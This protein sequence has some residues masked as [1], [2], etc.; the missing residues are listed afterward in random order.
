MLSHFKY[1][2]YK[3][4][5]EFSKE[6]NC[7]YGKVINIRDLVSYEANSVS[8]LKKSFIEAVDDYMIE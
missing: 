3:G 5:I 1:K 8:N 2:R 7:Y 6:D 4:T